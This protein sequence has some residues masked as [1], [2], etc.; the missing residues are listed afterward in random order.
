MLA[1]CT[2]QQQEAKQHDNRWFG[3]ESF[4]S[5]LSEKGHIVSEA[6]SLVR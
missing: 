4:V 1:M 2:S 5:E 6:L 3:L